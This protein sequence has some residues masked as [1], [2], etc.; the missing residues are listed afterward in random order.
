M[1][2]VTIYTDGACSGNPG[3]GGWAAVLLY[4]DHVREMAGGEEHTTNQRMELLAAIYAL[5]ALKEPCR[6]RLFSDSAYLVN[7]F[8]QGWH[9]R[10]R[11]N[12]WRNS[13]QE[14]VQNRELWEE[15]LRLTDVHRVD[16]EKVQGHAGDAWNERCDALARAATP[17]P[18]GSAGRGPSPQR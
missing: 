13:R 10:W 3:P 9:R 17:S 2:E 15:L 16:F 18:G 4:G 5:R 6:V 12:G 11:A 7:C 8:R 1:K 14:P